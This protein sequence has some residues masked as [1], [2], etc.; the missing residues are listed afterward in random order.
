[1]SRRPTQ[2]QELEYGVVEEVQEE[3]E[4]DDELFEDDEE[5]MEHQAG[6]GEIAQIHEPELDSPEERE[7]FYQEVRT[8]AIYRGTL[9]ILR[10]K[11]W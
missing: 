11:S 4:E 3:G 9:L 1:V 10:S 2:Q 8:L 6:H 5:T 7:K